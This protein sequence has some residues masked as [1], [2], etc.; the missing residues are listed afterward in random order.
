M[1]RLG[2]LGMSEGN[3]HPYSWSAIFNGY[4]AEG[5]ASCPFPAIPQYLAQRSFPDDGLGQWGRVTHVWTQ[6]RALSEH[7]ARASRIE[8]VVDAPEQMIGQV[9]AVL[10][11][12]DDA[13]NHARFAIPFV[14]AGLPIYIDKPFAVRRRD[15]EALLAEEKW[16]GQIFSC[17]ALR[18]ASELTLSPADHAALGRIVGVRGVTP[19]YWETYGVHI[20]EPAF[21]ILE[22]VG[23]ST[24]GI[25]PCRTTRDGSHVTVT[26]RTQ[27]GCELSFSA[28]GSDPSS[29]FLEVRGERGHREL[30]FKDSFV[31]F[32]AALEAFVTTLRGPLPIPRAHTLAVVDFLE[33]GLTPQ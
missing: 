20:V 29:I 33:L 7:I 13:A 21:A 2:V 15:A 4:D 11:A 10:L 5:M 6:E 3:G 32:R 27:S 26:G 16:D 31:A 9:D 14:R 30:T 18:Y 28:V 22:K 24:T 12:R 23:H 25:L 8:H 19:K 17:S 1:L